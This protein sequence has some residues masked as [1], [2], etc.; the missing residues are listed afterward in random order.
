M[1]WGIG[2]GRGWLRGRYAFSR[3]LVELLGR[4]E[5]RGRGETGRRQEEKEKRNEHLKLLKLDYE[6]V[7]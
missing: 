6:C 5:G 1:G 4:R 3:F 2:L 7:I